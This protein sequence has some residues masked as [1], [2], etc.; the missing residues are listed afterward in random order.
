M[1][2]DGAYRLSAGESD[3]NGPW[4]DPGQ[5]FTHEVQGHQRRYLKLVR[6]TS[7][8]TKA[9]GVMLFAAIAAL[10]IANA[11]IHE[12]FLA[13][14][15]TTIG[16]HLGSFCLDISLAHVIND[17]FMALF[18]LLVGL[19]IKYEATVGDLTDIRAA[20]LPIIAA[21]GGVVMPI[22]IF[23][24]FN[25]ASPDSLGGWGVPTATDIAFALGILALLGS[26]VPTGAKVFLST[27]AVADDII[28]I[29]VIA[30]FYGHS[31][32]FFW[33]GCA[34]AVLAL[35]ALLNRRH[36][37]SL[38][39]YLALGGV[40]WTFIYLSGVHSTIAGVLVALTIPVGS[41]VHLG[42]YLEWSQDRVDEAHHFYEEG[43]HVMGQPKYLKTLQNLCRVTSQVI[44]PAI[45]LEHSL[46]PWV[47]F[48]IL[49]LFA[50]TNADVNLRGIDFLSM[51]TSPVFLGV[52]LG[53]VA[54]KSLGILLASA[55]TVKSG[56]APLPKGVNWGHMAGV[57]IL[58]GVGFTMAIFVSN[59]A[60]TDPTLVATAKLAI[61]VASLLAGGLGFLVLLMQASKQRDAEPQ[62]G[63][64]SE[65]MDEAEAA[66]EPKA[67]PVEAAEPEAA[68]EPKAESEGEFASKEERA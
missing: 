37:Y 32:D 28:A 63:F 49:P 25:Y 56:L 34:G 60:F 65:G 20:I 52:L 53:L 47:Y 4:Y 27:L 43:A 58:G 30:I 44:P 42:R 18:F 41:R 21:C 1:S 23:C 55:I 66:A 14:W 29:L 54:G 17:V 16:F 64:E 10:V 33:L 48:G 40:L 59:L 36:V 50:L 11:G 39:P 45:R 35:L 24:A 12:A 13:F 26:R 2:N 67:E 15:H 68:T 3:G 5:V 57:S 9:A 46:Y 8:S 7:S 22:A 62:E 31:P 6:F 19:E 51:V 61:L 38:V